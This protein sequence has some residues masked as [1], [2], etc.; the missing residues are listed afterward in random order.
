MHGW[1]DNRKEVYKREEGAEV[2]M[3]ASAK[4]RV[5][6]TWDMVCTCMGDVACHVYAVLNG[7]SVSLWSLLFY[8]FCTA[9]QYHPLH[10]SL[11]YFW[12]FLPLLFLLWCWPLYLGCCL[13]VQHLSVHPMVVLSQ[14]FDINVLGV[15]GAAAAILAVVH[16]LL[17]KENNN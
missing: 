11:K 4:L 9:Y 7:R 10:Y 3:V 8:E 1:G 14:I 5:V 6:W 17:L 13:L 16:S 15:C 2:C 12:K